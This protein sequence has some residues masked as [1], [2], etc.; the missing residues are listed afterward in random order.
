[1]RKSSKRLTQKIKT[2]LGGVHATYMYEQI[3]LN[4]PVEVIVLGD[5]E[6]TPTSVN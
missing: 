2:L 3:I 5:G 6:I 4:L 1:L